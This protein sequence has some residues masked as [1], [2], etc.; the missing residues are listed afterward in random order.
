M[1]S[2][3]TIVD[4][5]SESLRSHYLEMLFTNDQGETTI[6]AS[7]TAFFY[8]TERRTFLVTARHN[9]AGRAWRTNELSERY[10]VEPNSI[11]VHGHV[12]ANLGRSVHW[13]MPLYEYDSEGDPLLPL[14]LE[15]P[16]MITAMMNGQV[17]QQV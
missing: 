4:V 6:Q 11:R 14:W 13:D 1:S 10:P 8:R 3:P 15:H 9:V 17:R 2:G 16:T 7:G 12:A 5:P